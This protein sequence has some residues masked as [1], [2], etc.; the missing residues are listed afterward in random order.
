MSF[1]SSFMLAISFL[2]A[3]VQ[4]AILGLLAILVIFLIFRLVAMVLNAIPFL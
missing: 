2:P 1:I 3:A 4:A